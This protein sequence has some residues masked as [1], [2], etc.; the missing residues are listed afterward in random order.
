VDDDVV[1]AAGA[2]LWRHVTGGEGGTD[3]RIAVIHRPKYDDWTL[4]KGKLDPGE[5]DRTAALREI[6]EE[7]A[8]RGEILGELGEVRYAVTSGDQRRDKVVRYFEMRV[9]A[10]GEFVPNREVDELRWCRPDDGADLLTYD[11]DR[12][13]LARFVAAG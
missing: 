5:D 4:P 13:V 8:H 12:E 1:R 9:V 2:V 10:E 7:T 11:R 3:L 6:E